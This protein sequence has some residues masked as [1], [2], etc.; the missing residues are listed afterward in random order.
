MENST[1]QPSQVT[2][3]VKR[4]KRIEKAMLA[5]TAVE[6]KEAKIEEDDAEDRNEITEYK[7]KAVSVTKKLNDLQIEKKS[8]HEQ[9]LHRPDTYIG[10][11]ET[12]IST[13]P[14]WTVVEHTVSNAPKTQKQ[15]SGEGSEASDNDEMV[16]DGEDA[17]ATPRKIEGIGKRYVGVNSGLLQIFVEV[18]SNAIDNVWRSLEAGITPKF[19]KIDVS[20]TQCSV[21]NDGRNISCSEH[22]KERIPI[23]ELIFGNLL[24]SSNYNDA[25]QRKTSGRNGYGVKLTNI[26]SKQFKVTIY[27]KD[28][29]VMYTQEWT[30]NMRNKKAPERK[31][32]GFPTTIE[33]GKNGFTKVEWTPDFRGYFNCD[34]FS[35]DMLNVIKKCVYDAAM[36]VSLNKVQVI[37]NGQPIN[38]T[39][40]TDYVN[41]YFPEAPKNVISLQ[42]DN[43]YVVLAPA[44]EWTAVSF[45]NGIFTKNHGVHV[46]AWAEALFRPVIEK[47]NSTKG[48]NI[49]MRELKKHFFMFVFADLVNPRFDEQSKTRLVAPSV[50]VDVKPATIA[51]LL[52]WDFVSNIEESL[53]LKEM[54]NFQKTTERKRG[55]TRVEN[56]EDANFA[57]KNKKDCVLIISEGLSA[58]T[59]VVGGMKYG[60]GQ[61]KGRDTIGVL[62]IKGKFL[63]VKNAS[64]ATLCKNKELIG[65]TKAL[66][67]TYGLDYTLDENFAKLRYKKLVVAAD[68]D[69]DGQHITGLLYNLFHTLYPTLLQRKGFFAF[70]RIPIIKIN[71]GPK[72]DPLMFYFQELARDYIK[73]NKVPS[74]KIRYFKGLGTSE[75]KDVKQDFGKRIVHMVH[76][77]NADTMIEN[78]FGG[79]ESDFRKSWL[80]AHKP[81]E[82]FPQVNLGEIEELNA[83]D[84]LNFEMI[85]Y[86]IDHCRR[87]IP[88][89]IDG[90][91]ESGRKVLFTAFK[92]GLKYGGVDGTNMKVAQF[93]NAVA[94]KTKYHHGEN[95][96]IETIVKMAQRFVGSNNLPLFFNAG[97]FGS[98]I[99]N[100]KDAADGRYIYTRLDMCTSYIF[101]EEDEA[102]LTMRED[103]GEVVEPEVFVPIVPMIVING[104]QGGIGTGWSSTIPPHNILDVVAWI[105]AWLNE[106]TLPT[107]IPFYRGF[108]GSVRVE[109]SKVITTGIIEESK[110][111]WYIKEIPIGRRMVSINKYQ[112]ILSQKQEAGDIKAIDNQSSDVAPSFSFL[113]DKENWTPTVDNMSLTDVTYT[114][115]M[116]LFDVEGKLKKYTNIA[117]IMLAW[118]EYR[119]K[120]YNIRKA[121][122][123]AKLEHDTKVLYNKI[124]FVEAVMTNAIVLKE[125]EE[126]TLITE[127]QKFKYDAM[128]NYDYLL[129]I[130]IRQ[131]TSKSVAEFKT[132]YASLLE[133]HRALANTT[134]AQMWTKELD[135]LVVAYKKWAALQEVQTTYE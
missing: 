120:Q 84:F 132:K 94:E 99:D 123:M 36:T 34:C 100:G 35:A 89:L 95:N 92:R 133:Q 68:A 104:I 48:R 71:Q 78:V 102:F 2:K 81:R 105:K 32:K 88:S 69:C 11:T 80:Q 50:S 83:S 57:G 134:V 51:K 65:I 96:L 131:M 64:A 74:N 40:L 13:D 93:A 79:E 85:N 26:F 91:K 121:G 52:K 60:F 98:R 47:L 77:T 114:S 25:E 113:V 38:I 19:I 112:S 49:D 7:H 135:E 118:C 110:K 12:I 108:K 86:S 54:L 56:L 59:Y 41:L 9:I 75:T 70:M 122:M 119:F 87:S 107:L 62:P 117:D 130:S 73:T 42:T 10:G 129:N 90:L 82:V 33:T 17:Y 4:V 30:N 58:R 115:N 128:P 125:K 103:D 29:K 27:N 109:G 44:K 76:D 72:K 1:A 67:V 6:K 22:E 39:K 53:K 111:R 66:G 3:T 45:V 23:P 97:Q 37:F 28:E 63:N 18:V 5:P 31:N 55:S 15:S 24:T 46:D 126:E 101:R 116:V 8:H 106:V 124:R 61:F 43:C 20:P 14:V 21:W 16:D 127:L